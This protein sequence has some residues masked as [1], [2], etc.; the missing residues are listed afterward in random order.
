MRLRTLVLAFLAVILVIAGAAAIFLGNIDRFRPRIQAEIQQKLNRPV[1]IGQLGLKLL[2]LQIKVDGLSIGESPAFPQGKPFAT[3]NEVFLSASLLSLLRGSPEVKSVVLDKPQI[4]LIKN[5]AGVWN[6][7]SLGGSGGGGQSQFSLASLKINDGQV[8]YT[9]Q[10]KKD[11]RGVYDHIDL[12]LSDFAPGKQFGLELGVH[13]PGEGRQMLEFSGKAG[14]LGTATENA[15]PPING[16]LSIEQVSLAGINKFASGTIPAGTDSVASGEADI[17]SLAD[18]L[19]CKGNLKLENTTLKGAKIDYPITATY[20]VEDDLKQKKLFIRSGIVQLGPTTFMASGSVDTAPTPP[21]LNIQLKTDNSSVTELA[22]LAGAFGVGFNPSYKVAG[23]LSADVSAKGSSTSP[24]LSGTVVAHALEASG[25]EIKQPVSIPEIDL[26]LSPDSIMSNTFTARSGGTALAIAFTLAQYATKNSAV[27]ATIKTEGAANVAELLNIAKAYGVDAAKGVSGDG[28]LTLDVHVKGPTANPSAVSYA[29]TANI[30]NTT[31]STPE[32]RKPL[33]FAS[34]NAAFS[35]NTVALTNL[36]ATVGG[37]TVRGSLS[38]RNFAAPQLTFNLNAD[39]IDTEELQNLTVAAP[40][41]PAKRGGAPAPSLFRLTTGTGTLS[42]GVIKADDIELKNVNAKCQLDK[43][44]VQLSPLSA[45]VFGGKANGALTA[46]TRPAAT[47]CAVK[48]KFAGVDANNMLS[49]VSSMKNTLYGSLAADTNV[50]FSLAG[51]NDLARTLNGAIAFNLTDGLI[52]NLNIINEVEKVG[53]FLKS[54]G[55]NSAGGGGGTALKKFTGTLN[56]LNGV[57]STDDL[58]GVL[59][60]GSIASKGTLNLAS[61]D[62]NMHLTAVLGNG[63][64]QSVGGKGIGGFLNT[65]LSNSKGELVVPVL[66]TGNM[67]HPI[68]TPDAGAMA[69]MKLTN[70]LPSAGD[71]S[72]LVSGKGIGGIL[73]GILGGQQQQQ[74]NPGDAKTKQEQ[75]PADQLNSI[76]DQ[77]RKKKKPQ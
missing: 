15:L 44:V 29:G 28:K 4:E 16:H 43:G 22:K 64:S 69:K 6:F 21:L 38:A 63:V 35:Q 17:N 23:K 19:A 40:A 66:V 25:G 2:P 32:L 74:Q 58:T 45:D 26:T 75:Q 37:T 52:K 20:A 76:L 50:H 33:S 8:G 57:A 73:G 72:K 36:A 1:S 11:G 12:K 7:S 3:A 68:V 54:A 62:V 14:P 46:D 77:F 42:A 9:D 56:I 31:L 13:F 70:L 18:V 41:S 53:K 5:A 71:P 39:K 55:Q 47:Q 24:Q 67:A 49:A 59:N 48:V 27:D 30:M 10:T 61:Q 60:V 34:A 65:A 51:G